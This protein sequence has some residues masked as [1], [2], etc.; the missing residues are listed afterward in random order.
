MGQQLGNVG[1]AAIPV[2]RHDGQQHQHR[3][4]KGV[5]EELVAGL[6]AGST[7]PDTDDQE[8]RQQRAFKEHIEHRQIERGEHTDHQRLQDQEDDH[9]FLDAL[10]DSPAGENGKWHQQRGEHH[11]QHRNAVHA[12]AIPNRIANPGVVYNELETGIGW[13][14]CLPHEQRQHQH[15]GRDRKGRPANGLKSRPRHEQDHRS[16]DKRQPGKDC[17]D[18]IVEVHQI[19]PPATMAQVSSAAMPISMAN[20]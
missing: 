13:I 14:K 15:K 5:E 7:P 19:S 2:H 3:A 11:E 16:A 4:G 18:G 17:E 9:V 6:D 10:L 1:S 20:A 12:D 8:H